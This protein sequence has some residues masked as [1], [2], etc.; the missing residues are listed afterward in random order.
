VIQIDR[1]ERDGTSH[2]RSRFVGLNKL[3]DR[4]LASH[5]L[6]LI[7]PRLS[8]L[9]RETRMQEIAVDLIRLAVSRMP[10]SFNSQPE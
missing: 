5:V 9:C 4:L 1:G 6:S 7:R 8:R 3:L 2:A 10:L